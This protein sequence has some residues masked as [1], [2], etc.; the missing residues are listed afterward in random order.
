MCFLLLY[1]GLLQMEQPPVLSSQPTHPSQLSQ[2]N[3]ATQVPKRAFHTWSHD[4]D[5]LLVDCLV[6]LRTEQKYMAENGF[7]NGHAQ[8][9]EAM[10][11]QK[12]PNCGLKAYPHI[13]SRI[14]TL[15]Q[16]WQTVYDMVFGTNTS[17]FGYDP[18]TKCVTADKDVWDEYIRV[19]VSI[20]IA[21]CRTLYCI[22]CVCLTISLLPQTGQS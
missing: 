11:E 17:G 6:T 8:A 16:S 9:L 20:V 21:L 7:K 15:K 19:W 3:E 22:C 13:V 18:E 1:I 5:K 14:R 2:P 10:M 12:A 4:E